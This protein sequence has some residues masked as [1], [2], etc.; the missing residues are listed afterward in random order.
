LKLSKTWREPVKSE[1]YSDLER[2]LEGDENPSFFLPP[3]AGERLSLSDP[4]ILMFGI[5]KAS[6]NVEGDFSSSLFS[7]LF[8]SYTC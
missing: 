5:L 3:L 2:K 4:F 7:F 6:W 1:S 8:S